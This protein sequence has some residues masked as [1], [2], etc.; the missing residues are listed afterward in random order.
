MNLAQRV[1]KQYIVCCCVSRGQAFQSCWCSHLQKKGESERVKPV[2]DN[3]HLYCKLWTLVQNEDEGS[4]GEWT[5]SSS[6]CSLGSDYLITELHCASFILYMQPCIWNEP[7]TVFIV[8]T[9]LI[10]A[11]CHVT[12]VQ[13]L[14]LLPLVSALTISFSIHTHTHFCVLGV[15]FH[16]LY[17]LFCLCHSGICGEEPVCA[18]RKSPT[19]QWQWSNWS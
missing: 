8:F 4:W 9:V 18:V 5:T 7:F 13:L 15:Y 2:G 17:P 11:G 12:S 1:D 16:L 19:D 10:C 14:K 6:S 3:L